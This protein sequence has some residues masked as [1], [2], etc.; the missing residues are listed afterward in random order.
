MEDVSRH[1]DYLLVGELGEDASRETIEVDREPGDG[2][3]ICGQSEFKE[4]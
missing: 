3:Q 1:N 2:A 4:T